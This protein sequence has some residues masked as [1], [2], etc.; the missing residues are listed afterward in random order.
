MIDYYGPEWLSLGSSGLILFGAVISGIGASTRNYGAVVSGEV[1][2]GLG[3]SKRIHLLCLSLAGSDTL[4]AKVTVETAQLKIY[5][6]WA[7]GSH[8]G[9]IYGMNNAVNRVTVVGTCHDPGR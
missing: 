1:I 5:T 7:H 6:H 3:S 2:V 4:C 8:L 9:L